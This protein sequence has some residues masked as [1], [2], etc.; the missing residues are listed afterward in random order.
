MI[1]GDNQRM[2][3]MLL[4]ALLGLSLA[5]PALAG[6]FDFDTEHNDFALGVD[7]PYLVEVNKDWYLGSEIY[8]D[9]EDTE[10][11]EGWTFLA[12]ATYKGTLFS[13][14]KE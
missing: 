2:K 6:D 11:D 3:K 13:F 12:K 10:G 8:K 4:I 9:I 7:A 5:T 14:V 1:K